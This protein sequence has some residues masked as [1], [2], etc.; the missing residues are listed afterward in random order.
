[1]SSDELERA[2]AQVE[3]CRRQLVEGPGRGGC[4]E[5]RARVLEAGVTAEGHVEETQ[6]GKQPYRAFYELAT[7]VAEHGDIVASA[8]EN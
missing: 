8:R 3:R 4:A 5:H 7:D 6:Y 1:V 2:P